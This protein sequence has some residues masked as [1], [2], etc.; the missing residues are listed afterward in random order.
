MDLH[1]NL[2]KDQMTASFEPPSLD[3]EDNSVRA[4]TV[5][6]LEKTISRNI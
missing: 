5:L 4:I 3:K 6:Q 2:D 1:E